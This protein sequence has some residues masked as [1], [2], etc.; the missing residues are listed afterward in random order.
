[1]PAIAAIGAIPLAAFSLWRAV[2]AREALRRTAAR[3]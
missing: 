3:P 1:V 2:T